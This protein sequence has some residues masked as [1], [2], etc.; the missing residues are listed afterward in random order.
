M[1][2]VQR[3]DKSL[4]VVPYDFDFSG[5]V[6]PPYA[7]PARGL[8]LKSVTDRMYRGPCR[9]QELVDPYV[10]NFVAK[11]DQIRALP[12]NIPGFD[13]SSRDAAKTFIDSFYSSIRTTKDVRGLFVSCSQKSTM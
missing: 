13:R 4:H 12:D 2:I 7:L 1:R 11:K 6:N 9:S 8:N 5:L 10:A 3:Q